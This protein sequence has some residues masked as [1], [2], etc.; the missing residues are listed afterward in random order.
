M[1]ER[2]ADDITETPD[3]ARDAKREDRPGGYYYDD[4]TGYEIY[5]PDEDE[6][7]VPDAPPHEERESQE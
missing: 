2:P 7:D 5:R 4:G 3:G 1:R 6:M